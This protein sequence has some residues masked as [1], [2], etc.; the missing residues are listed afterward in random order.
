MKTFFLIFSSL[1]VLLL[2]EARAQKS[3]DTPEPTR[4][5]IECEDMKGVAQD[6]FGPGK[7]WQVGR[8]GYDLYQ[9]MIFGGVWASRL[10]VAMTDSGNDPAEATS[11]IEVPADGAYKVWVKY[12]CP[13][14]FN[15]SFFSVIHIPA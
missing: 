10:R 9:N 11:E 13:P 2:P 8:W 12:E 5:I 7:G 3:A 6:K 14:F 15:T 1:T 4:I